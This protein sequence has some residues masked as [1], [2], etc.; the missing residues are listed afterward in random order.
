M[1]KK[2]LLA[3]LNCRGPHNESMP[4]VSQIKND[5]AILLTHQSTKQ[6]FDE[7]N[8]IHDDEVRLTRVWNFIKEFPQEW[9][10]IVEKYFS[11]SDDEVCCSKVCTG[12]APPEPLKC[13]TREKC[14]SDARRRATHMWSEHGVKSSVRAHIG[15]ITQ[16]PICGVE[17][18]QRVRLVK[19]LLE[20]R[21]RSKNRTESC[22]S[23]FLNSNPPIISEEEVAILEKRDA[24]LTKEA[25]KGGH[26]H[27]LALRPCKHTKPSILKKEKAA[28][29]RTRA[30]KRS[31]ATALTAPSK[32]KFRVRRKT[33]P[34][35][36]VM[37]P[38]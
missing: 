13:P 34:S 24:A 22:Q 15:D 4:R 1:G 36:L 25:R 33:N 28:S 5:I 29:V 27:V 12:S 21:I 2:P 8:A 6:V 17:F 19:H 38:K 18:H 11:T 23:A 31:C 32:P 9:N 3:V 7:I 14:F 16:C 26:S 10:A 35:M 37:V 30:S 20:N